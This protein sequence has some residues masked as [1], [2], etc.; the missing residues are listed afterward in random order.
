LSVI[1]TLRGIIKAP[2]PGDIGAT[3]PLTYDIGNASYPDVSFANLASEGYIKS[4]IVHA[5]IRELAVGAASAQYQVIAPSTEGGTVAVERGPLFDLMKRPNPAMSWY[6]FI[7]EFVTYLQVAGNV[8]TYKERNRGNRVTALQLLRPDRM[9]IVPGSYGAESY[10]YEVDGKDYMLPKDDVCHLALPNPGGD[11]YG[12]SPLQTLARTVNL[13]SAM[14]DFAKVYFQNAGV[15]SGLLK[16]KRRLQTQEEAATIRA[17]WR[18]QFGGKNNFHRVAILD[19]DADYQQMAS[20]PK[21][22]ALSELHNLTESR[23]CSV[24]QV[25]AILVGA[26]VGLQRST[27]SNYREARMAFHSETLE[28]MVARILDH[29]NFYITDQEYGGPE[30]ITVNWAAMRASLDDRT[31]ETTRVNALFT[32]GVITLNEARSTLGFEAIAGGDVRRIQASMFEVGEGEDVPVAVG[33]ASIEEGIA[34][35]DYKTGPAL[36]PPVIHPSMTVDAPDIKAPRVAPRAGMLRRQMLEDREELTDELTPKIQRYF[37]GLRNRVDGILGRYMDRDITDMKDLPFDADR[38]IPDGEFNQLSPV[39]RAAI[40]NISRK[41]FDA[42]NGNGLAGTLAWSE[43][44]PL[45]QSLGTSAPQRA[46]LIHS[47]T[48][49]AIKRAVTIALRGGYSVEQLAK[50]V[51]ADGFPG[52]RSIMTETEKRARLIARTEVMRTQNKTSVGFYKAQGFNFVRADDVDGDEDD[53]YIDPGD[54]YGFTCA[55]R[56]NQIYSVEDAANIDDHPNGTLNWQPM[57]R[58]FNPEETV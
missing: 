31:S 47:T 16:L 52:L 24:F 41:T 40:L 15:P 49:K 42:I 33:A 8:Y 38:L 17:R 35:E 25:P 45:I 14:T 55:E 34:I 56:H 51:P 26:N 30:Y 28:P 12:L 32:G 29:L 43:K 13:D 46:Q 3:V 20:A 22:M 50:G 5:C 36:I 18:S 19:E 2:A 10:V 27:Y 37:R 11:L 57:P 7:E 48:S 4:E 21:D 54:P 44:L 1:D 6:Q 39:L 23:I 53:T 58:D 9:R